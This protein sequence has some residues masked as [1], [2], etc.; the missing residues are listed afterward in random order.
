MLG[1]KRIVGDIS[2]NKKLYEQRIQIVVVHQFNLLLKFV[3]IKL[4]R[5]QQFYSK[6][7][8]KIYLFKLVFF[9]KQ[10]N[11]SNCLEILK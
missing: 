1:Y 11:E 4:I 5:S 6:N 9:H 2:A 7:F 3:K 10:N 8:I